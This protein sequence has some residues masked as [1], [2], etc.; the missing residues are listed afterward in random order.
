MW[1]LGLILV[2][3]VLGK[4]ERANWIHAEILREQRDTNEHLK[5]I[6]QRAAWTHI[7]NRFIAE[8]GMTI[9]EYASRYGLPLDWL[10]AW[11]REVN[12][13]N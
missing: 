2:L 3:L 4:L 8:H 11:A 13:T 1:W 7:H 12:D 6:R 10:R 5:R 9:E